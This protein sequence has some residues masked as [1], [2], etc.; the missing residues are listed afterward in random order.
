MDFFLFL[1]ARIRLVAKLTPILV[2]AL[3]TIILLPGCGGVGGA[4]TMKAQNR[5]DHLHDRIASPHAL[6]PVKDDLVEIA[7]HV[8]VDR[9][10]GPEY[11]SD[12]LNLVDK[13][14][15]RVDY[16]Y[17]E[18][19]SRPDIL[20]CSSMACYRK[21]GGVGLGYTRGN[22]I[23][24]SPRGWR[25]A[26][27]SHELSHV[28]LAARLGDMPDILDKVPQ[29]FDEGMAVMVSMAH[30]F[31]D[32]AWEEACRKGDGSPQ[33]S[34][35]AS[36]ADWNRVTGVNGVNMQ[37]SYGTARQEVARWYAAAG[38]KGLQQLIHALKARQEFHT[39][40]QGAEH[41]A[42]VLLATR[43]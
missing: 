17:G 16:F 23:L 15:V 26:I 12:L 8:F 22:T 36:M 7:P 41:A 31:S 27:I 1:L 28:E 43:D 24:I 29:W 6:H 35:L 13:A 40:Y 10:V 2:A 42:T 9:E 3:V 21:F 39:A 34:E 38:K 33:L 18:L 30:E 11:V 14:R 37:L 20:F 4:R 19:L 5:L 32:E 25:A